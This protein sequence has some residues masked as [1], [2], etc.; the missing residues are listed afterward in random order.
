CVDRCLNLPVQTDCNPSDPSSV[1]DFPLDN[2]WLK[3]LVAVQHI[4]Y[5]AKY[6]RS[7]HPS[8]VMGKQLPQ[9][10]AERLLSLSDRFEE[11]IIGASGGHPGIEDHHMDIAI[12]AVQLLSTLLTHFSR[13][14]DMDSIIPPQTAA[15][16]LPFLAAW[17]T[18]HDGQFLGNVS[19]RVYN[20]L[21]PSTQRNPVWRAQSEAV[22]RA[23][24]NWLVCG[25]P[26]CQVETGLKACGKCQTVRYCSPAHQ[27]AHW[28]YSMGKHKLCCFATNY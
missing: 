8:A 27:R 12:D 5:F 19:E 23:W 15:R 16:L 1:M 17:K 20:Y 3:I 7:L 26:T 11:R 28:N 6:L 9:V 18:R 14:S 21:S 13:G 24:K 22:R 4:P 25:L 2:A 10:I